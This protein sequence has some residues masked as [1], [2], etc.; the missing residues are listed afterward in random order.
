MSTYVREKVLRI[1]VERVDMSYIK[2][3]LTE[4]YPNEDHEDDFS[5]YLEQALPDVFDYATVGKFQTSPTE[6]PFFDY[7]LDYEYDA[8][9]EYGKTRAL[10]ENEKRKYL[11][12]FQKIDPNINMDFVRLVEF[13]WYNVCEA[14]D[15]YD[16]MNDPFYDEV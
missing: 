12:V 11:P 4:K 7:V 8:D 14:D 13:C 15:Y 1:P 9:G 6:R 10:T 3:I 16:H 2:S 5:F